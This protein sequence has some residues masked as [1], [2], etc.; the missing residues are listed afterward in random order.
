[1]DDIPRAQQLW[2]GVTQG[3]WEVTHCLNMALGPPFTDQHMS[4]ETQHLGWMTHVIRVPGT[5]GTIR[6]PGLGTH[7]QLPVIQLL[8]RMSSDPVLVQVL[9]PTC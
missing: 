7:W 9:L 1:M 6:G 5:W 4:M 2:L 8:G 3:Q